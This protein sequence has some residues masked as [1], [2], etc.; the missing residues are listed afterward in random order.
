MNEAI[1]RPTEN[2][3]TKSAQ[4]TKVKTEGVWITCKARASG[5]ATGVKSEETEPT[6]EGDEKIWWEWNGG[7]IVGFSD[8]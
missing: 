4:K 5:F 8:W 7:K 3:A 6:N 1:C 2:I